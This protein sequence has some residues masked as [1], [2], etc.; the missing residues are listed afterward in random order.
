MAVN[1]Q[2]LEL[3]AGQACLT[4]EPAY[5]GMINGLVLPTRAGARDVI[6]GIG[7]DECAANP[8]FR[9]AVLFPFP[10]RLRDGR[11]RCEGRDYQ[12]DLNEPALRNALHGFLYRAEAQVTEGPL[13]EG[14]SSVSLVYAFDGSEPGY[15]F[16]ARVQL[17]YVLYPEG[18]LEV[19]MSVVNQ[20]THTIPVGMGWHPYFSLGV[21]LDDCRLALPPARRTLV[22]ERMLPTGQSEPDTRFVEGASLADVELDNCFVLDGQSGRVSARFDSERAGFGLELWQRA[23][24][25]GM[26]FMQVYTSPDRKSLAVEPMSCGIDAFNT[27]EG[28]VNLEPG[29]TFSGVFGVRAYGL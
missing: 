12:F 14:A 20:G 10:N 19:C 7:R 1:H 18:E 17:D 28:L 13:V 15:P 27:G 3:R 25:R 29:Q 8:G 2:P 24:N 9:G 11:Y 4:L 16:R 26:N 21:A 22:D 6:A 23:G 5:G